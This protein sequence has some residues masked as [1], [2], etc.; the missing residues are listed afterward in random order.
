MTKAKCKRSD[1]WNRPAILGLPAALVVAV[2]GAFQ[3]AYRYVDNYIMAIVTSGAFNGDTVNPNLNPLMSYIIA[4]LNRLVP[5]ADW[6]TILGRVFLTLGIWWVGIL[7]ARR[8]GASR[9]L[10]LYEVILASV[11]LGCSLYNINYTVQAAAFAFVGAITLQLKLYDGGTRGDAIIGALFFGLGICWRMQGALLVVP[12]I[13][14][15]A[16]INLFAEGGHLSLK[17]AASALVPAAV[18]LAFLSGFRAMAFSSPR[19]AEGLRYD[20]ARVS[21]VDYPMK[22]WE[23]VKDS[24][25][26]MGI[27]QNDYMCLKDRI[28]ADTERINAD[29][30]EQIAQEARISAYSLSFRG[31]LQAIIGAIRAILSSKGALYLGALLF[32]GTLSIV[33]SNPRKEHICI[34]ALALLGTALIFTVFSWLGRIPGRVIESGFLALSSLIVC[35]SVVCC[36]QGAQISNRIVSHLMIGGISC[37]GL[38][39]FIMYPHGAPQNLFSI[40]QSTKVSSWAQTTKDT[41]ALYFWTSN[42]FNQQCMDEFWGEGFLANKDFLSRYFPFGGIQDGQPNVLEHLSTLV[43]S[44]PMEALLVRPETYLVA[45]EPELGYVLTYL[46]EHFDPSVEVAQVDTLCG[47]PVWQFKSE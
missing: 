35:E 41:N 46:Q 32:I 14:L 21:I 43:A 33:I 24:L 9:K 25:L 42:L 17:R 6:F 23:E 18:V 2:L 22:D 47:Y 44:N 29:C 5:T 8:L 15:P 31:L 30:M 39:G 13:L 37:I 26:P 19:Y 36:G 20:N 38:L 40:T 45:E 12:Y 4:G 28:L 27:T 34:L 7:L 3:P 10:V 16:V 1:F 11:C